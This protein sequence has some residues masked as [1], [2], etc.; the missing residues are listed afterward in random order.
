MPSRSAW[1]QVS[2]QPYCTTTLV[3][4]WERCVSQI[5]ILF[6]VK[7]WSG[8]LLESGSRKKSTGTWATPL[9]SPLFASLG[10]LTHTS[11][12][13]ALIFRILASTGIASG[14]N[15]ELHPLY[16]SA[17]STSCVAKL[18]LGLHSPPTQYLQH[19][20]PFSQR[21]DGL[22]HWCESRNWSCD[23]IEVRDSAEF[24]NASWPSFLRPSTTFFSENYMNVHT[25]K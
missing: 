18:P 16:I 5:L 1:L 25:S 9:A 15:W 19:V 8:P 21:Q 11:P 22:Y 6:R 10:S 14:P 2:E 3:I 13:F 24:G 4:A 17:T 23:C 20:C 7:F 12:R